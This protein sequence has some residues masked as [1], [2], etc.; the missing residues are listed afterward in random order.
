MNNA[1]C[2]L[3]GESIMFVYFIRA[4]NQGAIKIGVASDVKQRLEQ[5]QTGN[6]FELKVLA[7]IPCPCLNVA[8]ETEK[9]IH[10]LFQSQRIRGEWFQGTI[11]FAKVR[12]INLESEPEAAENKPKAIGRNIIK[13]A[14]A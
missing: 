10:R 9:R 5:L 3:Y 4:G 6:A 13:E 7:L 2:G 11:N 1:L 12:N 8:Y 14:K